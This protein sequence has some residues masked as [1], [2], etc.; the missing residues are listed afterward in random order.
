MESA[1]IYQIAKNCRTSVE[2]IE[3]Q[4]R[5]ESHPEHSG[6]TATSGAGSVKSGN[7]PYHKITA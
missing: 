6:L 5:Q 3:K 4:E 7:M 2:M 1:D